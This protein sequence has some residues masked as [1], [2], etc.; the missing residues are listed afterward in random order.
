MNRAQQEILNQVALDLGLITQRREPRYRYYSTKD[1]WQ[2]HWTTEK[3]GGGKYGC[4]VY[5]P[6]GP[7][8]RSGREG[9]RKLME[10]GKYVSYE[11]IEESY[12]ELR[13]DAKEKAY[14]RYKE[15]LDELR[16]KA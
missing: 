8:S 15:H 5:R 12:H 13:K 11:L 2:F 3:M 1:G 10:K 9:Q 4:G 16:A 14:R 6:R 7:G